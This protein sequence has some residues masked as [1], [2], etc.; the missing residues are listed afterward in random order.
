MSLVAGSR[1]GPY[2]VM[3]LM[4]DTRQLLLMPAGQT[5]TAFALASPTTPGAR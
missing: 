5:L 3:P 2:E 1:I 4:V